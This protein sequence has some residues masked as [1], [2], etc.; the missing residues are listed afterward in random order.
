M[1]NWHE[2]L[3]FVMALIAFVMGMSSLI[4]GLL[5]QPAGQNVMKNKVEYSFFGVSGLVV[6]LVFSYALA[7]A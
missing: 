6:C 4:M 1:S 7:T 2:P 5:P 3:I